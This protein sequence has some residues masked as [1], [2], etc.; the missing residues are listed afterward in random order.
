MADILAGL[1]R[2]RLAAELP[3]DSADCI[4]EAARQESEAANAGPKNDR[5]RV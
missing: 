3:K 1:E 2:A 4:V 5:R